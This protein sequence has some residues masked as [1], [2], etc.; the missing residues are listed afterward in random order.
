VTRVGTALVLAVSLTACGGAHG[1]P[2]VP[3]V[4]RSVVAFV[5]DGD[6]LRLTD[7]R[8]VRLVQIDAP[9]L[10]TECYGRAARRALIQL[11]PPGT[12]VTLERDPV[13][14][15]VDRY[16]R[17]LRY[18]IV[19]A[20]NVNLQLVAKGAAEPYFFHGDRGRLAHSLF[21]AAVSARTHRLGIW[22]T[23]LQARYAPE[24]GADTGPA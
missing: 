23:C 8:R 19:D 1:P 10:A 24:L 16:G 3:Q 4:S 9:E 5:N 20:R 14:D 17:L 13:L 22:G 18:V 11:A 2:A 7:G 12:R 21:V 15:A 6:T